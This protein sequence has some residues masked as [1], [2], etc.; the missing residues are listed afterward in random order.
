MA[1]ALG[2]LSVVFAPSMNRFLESISRHA[3]G[4]YNN[5]GRCNV[6]KLPIEW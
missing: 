2:V 1:Y 3:M 6:D 5:G 4:L